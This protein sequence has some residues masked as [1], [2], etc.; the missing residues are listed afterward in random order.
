[1]EGEGEG[2]EEGLAPSTTRVNKP[3]KAIAALT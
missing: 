1:M 3:K 2:E